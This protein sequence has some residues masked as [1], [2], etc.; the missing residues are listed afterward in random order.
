LGRALYL[1]RQFGFVCAENAAGVPQC[2]RALA[3]GAHCRKPVTRDPGL[4]M[5]NR[6]LATDKTV[7]QR[8]LT[9]IRPSDDRHVGQCMGL[10]H[11]SSPHLGF[12]R[13]RVAFDLQLTNA[14][15]N[16]KDP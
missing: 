1:L 15:C 11:Q 2:E 8:G 16:V 4:I 6:N 9:H 10:I 7:E 12:R 5:N 13:M 3:A 14:V